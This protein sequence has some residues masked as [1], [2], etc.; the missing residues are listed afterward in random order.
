MF[1]AHTYMYALLNYVWLCL[2]SLFLFAFNSFFVPFV[3]A[4]HDH[5]NY[6]HVFDL[7]DLWSSWFFLLQSFSIVIYLR[8]IHFYLDEWNENYLRG[9][10]A[11]L[12]RVIRFIPFIVFLLVFSCFNNYFVWFHLVIYRYFLFVFRF[13]MHCFHSKSDKY[14]SRTNIFRK[15]IQR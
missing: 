5:T 6:R 8:V 15:I 13:C 14:R 12:F 10:S 4:T 7:F 2:F 1:A 11:T 3:C 9:K